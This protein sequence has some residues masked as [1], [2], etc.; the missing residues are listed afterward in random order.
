M[1]AN[2]IQ[3][4]NLEIETLTRQP[5]EIQNKN[6]EIETLT[7]K[8]KEKQEELDKLQKEI[9]QLENKLASCQ[10]LPAEYYTTCVL[11]FRDF[12]IQCCALT[13]LYMLAEKKSGLHKSAWSLTVADIALMKDEELLKL[14]GFG[15]ARLKQVKDW[16]SKHGF[17]FV[18]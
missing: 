9:E 18:S 16:M 12:P 3:N 1:L 10:R 7:R 17:C 5:N 11:D 8:L 6:L 13:Q 15:P 14:R 2:E 4:K